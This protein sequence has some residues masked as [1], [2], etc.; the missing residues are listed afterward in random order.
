MS[1]IRVLHVLGKIDRGGAENLIMSIYRNMNRDLVQFDFVAHSTT[2]CA[3]EREIT[4][5]GGRV[6]HVSPFRGYNIFKYCKF[7]ISLFKNHPE[8]KI[9]HAHVRST[10]AIFL[11][12]AKKFKLFT[13]SHSHSTSTGK[14]YHAMVKSL[15]QI[16]IRWIADYFFAC[17]MD[18]GRWLFGK[19]IINSEKFAI[20]KNGIEVER[21]KYNREMRNEM[22]ERFMVQDDFVIGHVGNF[23][24]VKN[25]LFLLK[26]FEQILK[27]KK[28]SKLVL[29]GDGILRMEIEDTIQKKNLQAN[30]ILL[31]VR[32]DV[33][34]ILQ[35]C[36]V[37]IFPSLYEGLPISLIE[38]QANGLPILAN[39]D[40]ISK[41]VKITPLMHFLSV[42][43]EPIKWAEMACTLCR[44]EN[45]FYEKQVSEAGYDTCQNVEFLTKFYLTCHGK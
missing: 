45:R 42:T 16:P 39:C 21:F 22:R 9:V 24:P 4:A 32:D 8:I 1:C 5:L 44:D 41:E 17:S 20:L 12:I 29:V 3:F 37:I 23:L 28:K 30:V 36:D 33:P 14:G 34:L 25:H 31:G 43:E 7:W 2:P 10:A 35:M 27:I 40:G 18:A 13:I 11:I 26:V 15:L 6:F 19:S 38:A